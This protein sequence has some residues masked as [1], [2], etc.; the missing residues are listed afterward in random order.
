[1]RVLLPLPRKPGTWLKGLFDVNSL[2]AEK[3]VT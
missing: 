2:G 3:E 1:M